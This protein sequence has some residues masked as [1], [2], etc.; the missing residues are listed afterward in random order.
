MT[1]FAAM[2]SRSDRERL[3]ER[4]RGLRELDKLM[5]EPGTLA[6]PQQGQDDTKKSE[7]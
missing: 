4:L 5:R 6:A 7:P 2:L 1:T 3:L